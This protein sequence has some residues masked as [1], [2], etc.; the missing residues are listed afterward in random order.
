M[1]IDV[2]QSLLEAGR[3]DQDDLAQRF[4]SSY[5]WSRGYGPGAAKLLRRIRRGQDWQ[6][7]NRSVFP[8]GSLGNGGAMRAPAMGLFFFAAG[9]EAVIAAARASAEITHAHPQ[10]CE[11][12]V[13]IA[14]ATVFALRDVPSG[15]II[16]RLCQ[17][18]QHAD[19]VNKL[20]RART[21]L[22][23]DEAVS[24]RTVA[25]VL[26]NGVTA[27]DSCITAL[28]V[29]L[30]FRERPF[31]DLLAF[32]IAM[33]GDVDTIAAMAGAIWGAAR[34]LNALP[35]ARPAQLEQ[36]DRLLALAQSLA[37][38]VRAPESHG[39]AAPHSC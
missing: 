23:V 2:V 35:P 20:Q 4:A 38:R 21:W 32:V 14:L 9:E 12:A 31:D 33:R 3:V 7:A 18:A 16:K 10:G 39:C 25:T 6:S 1:T 19:F 24:P 5:R 36:C 27:V 28:F 11:G 22:E 13:V 26:G 15:E 34:G 8:D 30:R 29:A 17:T 37:D